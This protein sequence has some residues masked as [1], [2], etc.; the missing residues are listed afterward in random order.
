M[1]EKLAERLTGK[2]F[3]ERF[4]VGQVVE[5]HRGFRA[6][7]TAIG[8]KRFLGKTIAR[9]QQEVCTNI[10]NSRWREWRHD[11]NAGTDF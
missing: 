1:M 2:E 5:S 11:I 9:P 3:K 4:R 6:T 10:E 8:E 7:I